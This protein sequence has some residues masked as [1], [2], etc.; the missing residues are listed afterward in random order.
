MKIKMK[1]I[2]A[3]RRIPILGMMAFCLSQPLQ[4]SAL[5]AE[6]HSF[7]FGGPENSQF[8]LDGKPFHMRSGEIHPQRVPAQY[9]RHRI[10]MAKAMGLNTIGI[11]IFWNAFE[12]EEG[13]YD[14]SS[15]ENDVGA[16][17]RIAREEGMWVLLRPGPYCC[18]EWALGGIPP[19]LL[20]YPDLKLRTLADARYTKA[21]ENYMNEMAKVVRPHLV[22]NG[23]PILMVQIENEYGSYPRRDLDYMKWLVELWKK[24]GVKGPFFTGDGPTEN[25][26]QG[27]TLPG[28]AV[29]LDPGNNEKSFAI[30]RKM[31]PGVPVFSSETYTGWLTHWGKNDFV[32]RSAIAAMKF[33]MEN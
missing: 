10:Q 7:A 27:V 15:P 29:G 1:T 9:W 6:K 11:Y 24:N 17:L 12:K 14:F 30:A 32:P 13:K 31:N 28:V 2:S 3:L 8:L 33:F 19:Y 21:V 20:R 22:E 5:A 25:Y 16:F 18:G 26:L 4:T 23:G